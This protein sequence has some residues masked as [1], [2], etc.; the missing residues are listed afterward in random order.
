MAATSDELRQARQRLNETHEQFAKR[1][2]IDR[3]TYTGWERGRLPKDGTAPLLI[4]R[5]LAEL[6]SEGESNAGAAM[7]SDRA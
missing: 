5:V 3:S 2:G 4:E 1:F 6:S 7:D